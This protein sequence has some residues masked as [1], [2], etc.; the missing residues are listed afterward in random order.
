MLQVP[1]LKAMLERNLIKHAT[2]SVGDVL[3]VWHRGKP[4][5]LKVRRR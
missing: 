2:L 4:F 1:L 3:Q 5:D